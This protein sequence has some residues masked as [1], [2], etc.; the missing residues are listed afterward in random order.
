MSL[1]KFDYTLT[2]FFGLI[3]RCRQ[4]NTKEIINSEYLKKLC[5]GMK[6]EKDD[7]TDAGRHEMDSSQINFVKKSLS[8]AMS[9][10]ADILIRIS[11]YIAPRMN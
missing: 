6:D 1:A 5:E 8:S 7:L 4:D 3:R 10:K 2:C 9:R 11:M